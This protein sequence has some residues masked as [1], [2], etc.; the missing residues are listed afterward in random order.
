MESKPG[1]EPGPHWWEA[2]P[3]TT[4]PSHAPPSTVCS[5]RGTDIL[6]LWR[7]ASTSYGLHSF[8]YFACKTW[9]SLPEKI[10][11]ESTLAG[12]KCLIRTISFHSTKH[13]FNRYFSVYSETWPSI[14]DNREP[15]QLHW[16]RRWQLQ[17]T[18]DLMIKTTA[19]H[20]HHAF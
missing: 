17:K 19:L 9:N 4:A 3:L 14:L 13:L 18:M 10:R 20:V 16:R 11:M 5:L 12:F 8:N 1:F 7:P 2:S 6:S 15:K